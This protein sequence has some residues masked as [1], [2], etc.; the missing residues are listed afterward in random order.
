M[1]V[2]DEALAPKPR[3]REW[4]LSN[5]LGEYSSSTIIG[6]NTRKY[7]GLWI[8]SEG[9][10][11]LHKLEEEILSE[12]MSLTQF[13]TNK[14][15]GAIHP[16]GFTH[17]SRFILD[18]YPEFV[19]EANNVIIRK[20]IL[21]PHNKAG[22]MVRYEVKNF[23]EGDIIFSAH[24]L[25]N[26][27]S[28]HSTTTPESI[29]FDIDA[30]PKQL[31]IHSPTHEFVVFSDSAM[32]E[33]SGLPEHKRWYR[34]YYY[35][36]EAIRGYDPIDS[37]YC[38]G[39][40]TL[41]IPAGESLTFF[42]SAGTELFNPRTE[43]KKEL[44]RRRRLVASEHDENMRLLLT[45]ADSFLTRKGIIAGYPW[46]GVWGRDSLVSLPGLLLSTNRFADAKRVLQDL[47]SRM[48]KGLV[49]TQ[50]SP[51]S[52]HCADSSLWF[53][54]AVNEYYLKSGDKKFMNSMM[55]VM[56]SIIRAYKKGVNGIRVSDGLVTH[57]AGFTW[58]DSLS[59]DGAAVEV[60][61]LW[62]NALRI[63]GEFKDE[64][65]IEAEHTRNVFLK[66]F[67][68]KKFL[69]DTA[70]PVRD[71]L[72]P[73]Q[74]IALSLRHSMLDKK[75]ARKILIRVVKE[76]LT[77]SGLRTLS[78]KHPDYSASAYHNGAV[79]PWL[80]GEFIKAYDSFIG[81]KDFM[82]S[83]WTAACHDLR[84]GGVGTINEALYNEEP[85]GCPS[86]A[87]SV[88]A[89]LEAQKLLSPEP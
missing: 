49:P 68:N 17:Q 60:Q 21:M 52:F 50:L 65:K 82:R 85:G 2:I 30:G 75:R 31:R 81:D 37:A 41:H 15:K 19:Y 3:L 80:L 61:A 24:A 74:V 9:T 25:V 18:L 58:M 79:W 53:I 69:N 78:P 77:P 32:S 51:D 88:S 13:S 48:K 55:S 45:A 27:R 67:W 84:T 86:Q 44:T 8:N 14:Y 63:L 72:R 11:L 59:R 70:F 6:M 40:F 87:W 57:P 10:L 46:F 39:R 16:R 54:N 7:H 29:K 22:V 73:N 47:A 5:A 42:I 28:I 62:Y 12:D 38:P 56:E 71:E 20:S 64:Y 4:V 1:I 34:D 89:L 83:L 35:D 43:F 66:N 76:L 26:S 36:W 33:L 23:Q